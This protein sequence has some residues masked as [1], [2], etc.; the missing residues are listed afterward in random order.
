MLSK[1]Q[2]RMVS[3]ELEEDQRVVEAVKERL[4]KS[5]EEL[6]VELTERRRR[7]MCGFLGGERER[8]PRLSRR[9]IL[10]LRKV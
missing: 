3:L 8:R 1:W 6:K 4:E 2:Q 10:D 7:K 9:T 5:A